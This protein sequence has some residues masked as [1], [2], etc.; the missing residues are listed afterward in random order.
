DRPRNQVVVLLRAPDRKEACHPALEKLR[1]LPGNR[2]LQVEVIVARVEIDLPPGKGRRGHA[3]GGVG[4]DEE[5]VLEHQRVDVVLEKR[6]RGLQ[7]EAGQRVRELKSRQYILG[8]VVDR[9]GDLDVA[10]SAA[11]AKDGAKRTKVFPP[12]AGVAGK[13]L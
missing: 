2:R 10:A 7:V 4:G 6:R 8:V 1:E 11:P 9:F 5:R 3:G 12:L 13:G